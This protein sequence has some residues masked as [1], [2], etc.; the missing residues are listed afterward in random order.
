MYTK[1]QL[2]EQNTT[3]SAFISAGEK[4]LKETLPN[5]IYDVANLYKQANKK[6]YVVGGAVRDALSGV[7][8]KDFDLATDAV[9]DDSLKILK[10]LNVKE[11]GKA[12]GVVVLRTK[13]CPEGYEIASFRKDIS[14]GRNPEVEQGV[15]IEEDVKR[16]DLT[17]NALFY[18]VFEGK[19]VDLV[20]GV[21][22]L[23]DGISRTVGNAYDRFDEDPLRLIRAVRFASRYGKLDQD[24]FDA[25][26]KLKHTLKP[27]NIELSDTESS[28]SVSRERIVDEFFKGFKQGKDKFIKILLDTGLIDYVF[29]DIELVSKEEYNIN[30]DTS[31]FV[32]VFKLFK[33]YEY[34]KDDNILKQQGWPKDLCKAIH[35]LNS[36]KSFDKTNVFMYYN[37]YKNSGLTDKDML[38]VFENTMDKNILNTF[39]FK[40]KPSVNG[41]DL[42]AKGFK[43][44][45]ISIE[46]NRLESEI[47]LNML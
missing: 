10:G 44:N 6:L 18:D 26:T 13:D 36:F 41:N 24:T 9:S 25:I 45:E 8:P 40:Y 30:L 31:L 47:F 20:G 22:D 2:F 43:G 38:D 7:K 1:I 29:I 4:K 17:I 28:M 15:S 5:D 11:Q 16:R 32:A 14:K 35:F 3:M 37:N 34:P 46:K 42:I 19:I 23:M 27:A 21:K 12:F 39:L 33:N